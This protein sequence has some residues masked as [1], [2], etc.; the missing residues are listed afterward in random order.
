M[1]S[2]CLGIQNVLHITL[3]EVPMLCILDFVM[4]LASYVLINIILILTFLKHFTFIVAS[5]CSSYS[6]FN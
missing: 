3:W 1:L 6:W 2:Y 5:T 4:I